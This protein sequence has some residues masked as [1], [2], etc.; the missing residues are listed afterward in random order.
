MKTE[1]RVK[2]TNGTEGVL[3]EKG[4]DFS[5][6]VDATGSKKVIS[7]D[8]IDFESMTIFD[9]AETLTELITLLVKRVKAMFKK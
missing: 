3:L 4:K 8:Y 5:T 6:I 2:L 9:I 1:V 7:N